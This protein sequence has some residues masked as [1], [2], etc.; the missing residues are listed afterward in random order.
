[1]HIG[2][3]WEAPQTDVQPRQNVPESNLPVDVIARMYLSFLSW[4]WGIGKRGEHQ[5]SVVI[6]YF[7]LFKS[8][9]ATHVICNKSSLFNQ[10]S[11]R[12]AVN[13]L[14]LSAQYPRLWTPLGSHD[15]SGTKLE[16]TG[17]AGRRWCLMGW[18]KRGYAFLSMC[19][20]FSGMRK[21]RAC[22][23]TRSY[24][25][26]V[27]SWCHLCPELSVHSSLVP[28]A[29]ELPVSVHSLGYWQL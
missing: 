9:L 20:P 4:R 22:S 24:T 29:P 18:R 5:L 2:M 23:E 16:C 11:T 26:S 25:S 14:Q 19:A 1:M 10:L 17:S 7:H 3:I 6:K 21:E 8:Q 13:T 28:D 15:S 27:P 12:P